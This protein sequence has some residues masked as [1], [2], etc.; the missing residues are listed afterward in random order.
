M[1]LPP[2]SARSIIGAIAPLPVRLHVLYRDNFIFNFKRVGQ[3]VSRRES[4][5]C[6]YLSQNGQNCKIKI[7]Q[8]C[9]EDKR[10][11]SPRQQGAFTKKFSVG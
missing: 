8:Y 9:G 3:E 11:A 4:S 6:M 1:Q 5:V 2:S 10:E 7:A